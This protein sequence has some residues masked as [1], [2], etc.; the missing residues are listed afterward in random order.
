MAGSVQ[1]VSRYRRMQKVISA[2]LMLLFSLVSQ[3]HVHHHSHLVAVSTSEEG[4]VY[5]SGFLTIQP[6]SALTG[7]FALGGSILPILYPLSIFW[8]LLPAR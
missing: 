5:H 3:S 8:F 4:N 7:A 6:S 1:S 2:L